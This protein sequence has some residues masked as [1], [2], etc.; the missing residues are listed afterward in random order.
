V[1][2][3]GAIVGWTATSHQVVAALAEAGP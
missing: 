1:R 2:A 3:Q